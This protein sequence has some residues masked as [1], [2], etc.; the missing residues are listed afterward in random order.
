MSNL[1]DILKVKNSTN[2]SAD[3]YFYGDIVSAWWQ[4]WDDAD[5]YPDAIKD[6]LK[7]VS[8]KDLNIYINSGGGSVFA[9]I[10]IYNML[11]RHTG[12]KTVRIDG[13]AASIASII[14]LSADK[15]IIPANAF[16]MI[17]KAWGGISGNSDEMRKYADHLDKIDMSMLEIYKSNLK[18]EADIDIIRNMISEETWLTGEEACKY[19]NMELEEP[20]EAVAY[21]GDMLDKYKNTPQK[22]KTQDNK[23]TPEIKNEIENRKKELLLKFDFGF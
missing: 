1:E 17:H 13:V 19:F 15:V 9:G 14:A 2:T 18:N 4:S 6:F 10:A 8:G 11:K 22:I 12:Y 5:Q 7:D 23:K 20:I 16:F 21:S 3:L